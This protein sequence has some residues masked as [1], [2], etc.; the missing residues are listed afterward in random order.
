MKRFLPV[1]LGV[2][3]LKNA[4]FALARGGLLAETP[5]GAAYPLMDDPAKLKETIAQ[6]EPLLAQ[7]QNTLGEMPAKIAVFDAEFK[8]AE[9]E[10][11]APKIDTQALE[12][13]VNALD[14]QVA[15]LESC[16]YM[17]NQ[18]LRDTDWSSMA[19]GVEVRVPFV[20]FTLLQALGPAIASSQPPTKHDLARCMQFSQFIAERPKT[21]FTTPVRRWIVERE[22]ASGRG[23]RGWSAHVHNQFRTND[24]PDSYGLPLRT[25]A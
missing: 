16:W 11:R 2:K 8:T 5:G 20:D 19:H 21:G 22:A 15:A 4:C 10:K 3:P 1:S 17:R 13:Q 23:L 18:L 14:A 9:A 6:T 24:R 12:A 25:A 7:A